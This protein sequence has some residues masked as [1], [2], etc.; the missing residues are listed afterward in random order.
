[1]VSIELFV[2]RKDRYEGRSIGGTRV[3]KSKKSCR[4]TSYKTATA[5]WIYNY[6]SLCRWYLYITCQ[7]SFHTSESVHKFNCNMTQM[8]RKRAQKQKP[9]PSLRTDFK[10]KRNK[11][12][13]ILWL[14]S[15][16]VIDALQYPRMHVSHLHWGILVTS[17][18]E[19]IKTLNLCG[20]LYVI[21]LSNFFNAH[22]M[23]VEYKVKIH[24]RRCNQI[25]R[26]YFKRRK[27]VLVRGA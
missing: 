16:T 26:E 27:L 3:G 13:A 17:N 14:W 24:Y 5:P 23:V 6:Y 10:L 1:M 20:R 21:Y 8:V 15:P 4:Q 25:K 12:R 7:D 11:F 9:W 19:I 18:L 22:V 2:S